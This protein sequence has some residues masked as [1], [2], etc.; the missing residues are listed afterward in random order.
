MSFVRG[1]VPSVAKQGPSVEMSLK[2]LK[3]WCEDVQDGEAVGLKQ[4]SYFTAAGHY[5]QLLPQS[6]LCETHR[7]LLLHWQ[8]HKSSCFLE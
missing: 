1:E 8:A 2:P 6:P 7:L 3:N 4:H 5:I